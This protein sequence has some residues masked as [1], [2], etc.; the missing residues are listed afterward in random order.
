M[1][2]DSGADNL[3]DRTSFSAQQLELVNDKEVDVLHV[4]ALL[5][6]TYCCCL[7]RYHRWKWKWKV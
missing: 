7:L 2:A 3:Q 4:L 5:P 1:E 6:S